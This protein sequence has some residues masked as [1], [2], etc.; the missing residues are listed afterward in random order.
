MRIFTALF[1]QEYCSIA[2]VPYR[3]GDFTPPPRGGIWARAR[4]P[5]FLSQTIRYVA[6]TFAKVLVQTR[7]LH[8][9]Y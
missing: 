8:T 2:G 7:N 6:E 4:H 5:F 9:T 1:L 3:E